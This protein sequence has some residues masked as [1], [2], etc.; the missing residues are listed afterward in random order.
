VRT[1]DE[2]SAA[3]GRARP[4]IG[5]MP[6]TSVEATREEAL[7]HVNVPGLL[8]WANKARFAVR[9]PSGRFETAADLEGQLVAGTPD[10]VVAECR[11]FEAL[12]LDQLVFDLRF[13]FDRWFA[14]IERL[15]EDVLPRLGARLAVG[16]NHR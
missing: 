14:Q 9:P 8:A 3:A 13:R 2:L 10:D 7:A 1:L 4:A 12:G 11:K 5:V 15:G 6:P 16:G